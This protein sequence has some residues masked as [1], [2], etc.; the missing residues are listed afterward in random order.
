MLFSGLVIST[1]YFTLLLPY[2]HNAYILAIMGYAYAAEYFYQTKKHTQSYPIA[3]LMERTDLSLFP[4]AGYLAIGG[5]DV[6]AACLFIFMHTWSQVHLAINDL[7]DAEND[8]KKRMHTIP[9]LYGIDGTIRWI[10][11]FGAL[12]AVGLAPLMTQIPSIITAG[13]IAAFLLLLA[14]VLRAVRNGGH[15]RRTSLSAHH[16]C[17]ASCLHGRVHCWKR[18]VSAK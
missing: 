7:A 13:S 8:I 6:V 9:V 3:Q 10:V 18:A 4:V 1:T 16:A 14:A 11:A 5:P 17:I 2:P 12:H 15:G